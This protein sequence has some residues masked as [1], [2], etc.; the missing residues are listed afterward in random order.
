MQSE[1][2]CLAN[3]CISWACSEPC[4][5]LHEPSSFAQEACIWMCRFILNGKHAIIQLTSACRSISSE[6][7]ETRTCSTANSIRT[8]GVC[9]TSTIISQAFN[10]ICNRT[11]IVVKLNFRWIY[12]LTFIS[13][14][15]LICCQIPTMSWDKEWDMKILDTHIADVHVKVRGLLCIWVLFTVKLVILYSNTDNHMSDTIWS[16]TLKLACCGGLWKW[17]RRCWQDQ[18]QQWQ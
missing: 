18:R 14:I 17:T 3:A 10:N 4:F 13:R 2:N 7:I 1:L 9:V 12:Q 16:R 6:S 11:K 8:I 5:Q 15:E